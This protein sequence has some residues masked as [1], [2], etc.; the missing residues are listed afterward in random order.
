MELSDDLLKLTAREIQVL[1]LTADGLTGK[2]IG[3]Q[4]EISRRTVEQY[5]ETIREKLGAQ[6]QAE[7]VAIGIRSGIIA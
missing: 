7:A 4:F 1:K 3:E 2:E 5:R 6:N